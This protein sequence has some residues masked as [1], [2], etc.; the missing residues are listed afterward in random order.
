MSLTTLLRTDAALRDRLKAVIRKPQ[1]T[2]PATLVPRRST[3]ANLTGTAFDYLLRFELQ[4]RHPA[5][6]MH[7]G[8][9]VAEYALPQAPMPR[10]ARLAVTEARQLHAAFVAGMGHLKDMALTCTVLAKFDFIYR[11]GWTDPDLLRPDVDIAGELLD[12][13]A[14]VPWTAFT[15]ER[16]LILNPS[17][18][19]AS[20]AVGGADAD[21]VLD[22]CLIDVKTTVKAEMS[23]DQLRQLVGYAVLAHLDA[24]YVL[25]PGPMS[26][27]AGSGVQQVGVYYARHGALGRFD[28][29]DIVPPAA[30]G[31]VVAFM[32]HHLEVPEEDLVWPGARSR[33]GMERWLEEEVQAAAAALIPTSSWACQARR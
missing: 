26:N 11:A 22:G 7:Q 9:W 32:R 30:W 4:R 16:R 31:G 10:K 19:V 8:W 15:A 20:Q 33:S 18:G 14:V 25:G 24:M 17:F 5:I 23:L 3:R 2:V 1:W 28:L 29:L 27:Y 21:V 6:A 12:L 13:L